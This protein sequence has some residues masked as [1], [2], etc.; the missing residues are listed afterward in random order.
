MDSS[1]NSNIQEICIPILFKLNE[2]IDDLLFDIY[3][4]LRLENYRYMWIEC[5]FM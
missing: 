5:I 3:Y 4:G 1:Y 2:D